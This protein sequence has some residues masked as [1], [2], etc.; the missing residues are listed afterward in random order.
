ME[1]ISAEEFLKQPEKVQKVFLEW[2]EI[3]KNGY[4]LC[5]L[6]IPY[7]NPPT[8]R[9]DILKNIVSLGVITPLFTEGQLRQ[10]IEG[11]TKCKIDVEWYN[12]D[13]LKGCNGYTIS[14]WDKLFNEIYRYEDLG[15]DLLKALW[16]VACKIASEEV[17]NE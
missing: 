14:F 17:S 15:K 10:F 1:Y 13:N 8:Y 16:Q 4:D 9:I 3:N 2:W 5:K 6:D 11:K 7:F 12:S